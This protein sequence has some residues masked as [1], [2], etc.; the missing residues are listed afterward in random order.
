MMAVKMG[1]ILG[2]IAKEPLSPIPTL[3][4]F[5]VKQKGVSFTLI[6]ID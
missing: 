6:H 5:T 1:Q 2:A 4:Q 3:C